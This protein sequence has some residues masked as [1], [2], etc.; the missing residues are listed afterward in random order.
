MKYLVKR[1]LSDSDKAKLV[2]KSEEEAVAQEVPA[3]AVL[4]EG[5]IVRWKDLMYKST[6]EWGCPFCKKPNHIG[7]RRCA[8]CSSIHYQFGKLE[9]A[10]QADGRLLN[11]SQTDQLKLIV[12]NAK[13]H[14]KPVAASPDGQ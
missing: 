7:H 9:F 12:E 14:S 11:N 2:K 10:Y 5:Q 1:G 4:L 6:R 8:T 13:Y 3:D